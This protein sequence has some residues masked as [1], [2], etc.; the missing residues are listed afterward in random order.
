MP[1]EPGLLESYMTGPAQLE[2]AISLPVPRERVTLDVL[3]AIRRQVDAIDMSSRKQHLFVF[4]HESAVE[5]LDDPETS[6]LCVN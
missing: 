6:N 4:V 3:E 5:T 1:C 2:K